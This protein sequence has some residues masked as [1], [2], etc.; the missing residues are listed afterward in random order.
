MQWEMQ[1]LRVTEIGDLITINVIPHAMDGAEPQVLATCHGQVLVSTIPRTPWPA[2]L[3]PDL[4][5]A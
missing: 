5:S 3:L 1:T 2:M 4:C